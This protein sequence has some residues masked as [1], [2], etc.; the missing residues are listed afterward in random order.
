MVRSVISLCEGVK[1]RV[2]V[3]C[4]LSEIRIKVGCT[5][6]MFSPFFSCGGCCHSLGMSGCVN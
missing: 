6:D 3:N 4:E 2:R 1:T 5:K